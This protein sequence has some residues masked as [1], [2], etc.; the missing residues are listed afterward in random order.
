MAIVCGQGQSF[1][2]LVESTFQNIEQFLFN[3]SEIR[4][5]TEDKL[6]QGFAAQLKLSFA[7]IKLLVGSAIIGGLPVA[8]GVA[9]ASIIT[10]S[11]SEAKILEN[12]MSQ[13]IT[14]AMKEK[15]LFELFGQ[16][17]YELHNINTTTRQLLKELNAQELL[18][19][20]TKDAL[21]DTRKLQEL[22]RLKFQADKIKIFMDALRENNYDIHKT[23]N[24]L[25]D[26][27]KNYQIDELNKIYTDQVREHYAEA[28]ITL[29]QIFY[30]E[31]N[32]IFEFYKQYAYEMKEAADEYAKLLDDYN[33][34]QIWLQGIY[35]IRENYERERILEAQIELFNLL[36]E[37]PLETRDRA[38]PWIYT[39]QELLEMVEKYATEEDKLRI[40]KEIFI[41]NENQINQ[42]QI[43]IKRHG[44]RYR[45]RQRNKIVNNKE[46]IPQ[47]RNIEGFTTNDAKKMIRK[48]KNYTYTKEDFEKPFWHLYSLHNIYKHLQP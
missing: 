48:R 18:T 16:Q 8:T 31:F 34:E 7:V 6:L 36:R 15:I 46:F 38:E 37:L 25:L 3:V 19:N 28:N 1:A 14:D 29:E 5:E 24:D 12:L 41:N 30:R 4:Q 13:R 22:A 26:K 21:I 23:Y 2:A 27:F 40:Y 44:K 47:P 9:I 11:Y 45:P 20:Y 43:H 32:D 39:K 10:C 35:E 42:F 33:Q 17:G